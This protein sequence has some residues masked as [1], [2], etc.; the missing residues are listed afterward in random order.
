[1]VMRRKLVREADLGR[2]AAD[3]PDEHDLQREAKRRGR[4]P[5]KSLSRLFEA[6]EHSPRHDSIFRAAFSLVIPRWSAGDAPRFSPFR[7]H[8]VQLQ[9]GCV[10]EVTHYRTRWPCLARRRISLG[11]GCPS[12]LCRTDYANVCIGRR[13]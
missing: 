6:I 10:N 12:T 9:R 1:N 13:E 3:E 11:S 4:A 2:Q 7:G 8:F 5:G